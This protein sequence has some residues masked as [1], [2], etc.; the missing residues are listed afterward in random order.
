[1]QTPFKIVYGYW[2]NFIVP[3]GKQSNM[4]SVNEQLD[5]LAEV[6]KEAEAVLQLSKEK[7]KE[8]FEQNKKSAH[9]FNVGDMVWLMAMDIKIH[10]KTPKLSPQQLSPF[11]VLKQIRDLD[12]CLEIPPFL[13]VNPV[14]YVSWLSLW[15]NN[16]INMP[17]PSE[18]V[19]VQSEEE[20]KVNMIIDSHVFWHQLQYLVYWKGYSKGDNTWEPTKNLTHA[21]KAITKFHKENSAAPCGVNAT[22]FTK[23]QT[24]FCASDT[25]TDLDLFSDLINL[26]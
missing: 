15:H 5:C 25:W 22:L 10:Q 14:F 17:L 21:K 8:Q 9:M 26:D 6:C 19:T 7:I 23:L 12:Y 18:P 4:P 24:F 3:I 11:K 16:G 1:M 20:Y 2:P 13:K